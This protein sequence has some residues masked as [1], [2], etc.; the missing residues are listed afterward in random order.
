MRTKQNFKREK[1]KTQRLDFSFSS[2]YFPFF[3]VLFNFFPLV[4]GLSLD[5]I[6]EV[7][8]SQKSGKWKK[9]KI[10]FNQIW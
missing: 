8:V 5:F 6:Y 1:K 4:A 3:F 10:F 9:D 7:K 2:F